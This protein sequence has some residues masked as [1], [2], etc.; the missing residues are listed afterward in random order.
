MIVSCYYYQSN[1]WIFRLLRQ[2]SGKRKNEKNHPLIISYVYSEKRSLRDKRSRVWRVPWILS[3]A[4]DRIVLWGR[5]EVGFSV[6][7]ILL[8]RSCSCLTGTR[9]NCK[10]MHVRVWH[11]R[12][13]GY[14]MLLSLQLMRWRISF[15]LVY[16]EQCVILI[17][18]KQ[19]I[20]EYT[21]EECLLRRFKDWLL[22]PMIIKYRVECNCS[23]MF[24]FVVT[25]QCV[26]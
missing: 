24:F 1:F 14:S 11:A 21:N 3:F 22:N 18:L 16:L 9:L 2:I 5:K 10:F 20:F 8:T 19:C 17:L 7:V 26:I 13:L 25:K 12:Y 6:N 23:S 15:H 4:I